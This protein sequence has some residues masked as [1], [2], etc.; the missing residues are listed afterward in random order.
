M[1]ISGFL[2]GSYFP[3]DLYPEWLQII[4]DYLPFSYIQY[5]PVKILMGETHLFGKAVLMISLWMVPLAFLVNFVWKRGLR[6]YT[7]AG[8]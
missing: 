5:Y 1:L 8:M 4:L 6:R 7:A 3:L 2:A